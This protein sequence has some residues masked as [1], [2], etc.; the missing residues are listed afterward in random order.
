MS[1]GGP[2][3]VV[4]LAWA[5]ENVFRVGGLARKKKRLHAAFRKKCQ[6]NSS[7]TSSLVNIGERLA[8]MWQRLLTFVS[9]KIAKTLA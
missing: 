7:H 1:D 4:G 6:L 5:A 9:K 8:N 2:E 3:E